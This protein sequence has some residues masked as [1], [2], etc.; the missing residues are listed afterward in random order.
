MCGRYGRRADKQ[1]IAEWMQ[2]HNTNV[3]E[4]DDHSLS[5]S[6]NIC[7]QSFQPVVRLGRDTDHRE[8]SI[9]RWGLIPSWS[10]DGKA[11]FNTMN[12]RAESIA[13]S[14]VYR[15]AF[16]RRRCLVP[17]DLFYEWQ[18]IDAKNKVPYAITMSDG[19]I[20][21][22]AGLWDRWCDKTT[23]QI[24]ETYTIV[25]TDANELMQPIHNR[26]PVIVKPSDY[27]RWLEPRDPQQL[28]IDLLRP[29]DAD[30]MTAWRV[31]SEV[32]NIRNNHPGL[33]EP[34]NSA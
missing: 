14:P 26:M 30:A 13:T 16:K 8:L 6:Y 21:A 15:D 23:G 20:F 29:F 4:G 25:T 31:G 7:P 12:A 10:K 11:A 22:F 17:A 2:N 18:R 33:C 27:G 9:M 5:P 3:F 28:P 19:E 1:K 34:V 24:L 32:G